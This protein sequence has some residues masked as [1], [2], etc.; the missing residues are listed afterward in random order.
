M[1]KISLRLD[2]ANSLEWQLEQVAVNCNS[3][4]MCVLLSVNLSLTQPLLG[5]QGW[6]SS[7]SVLCFYAALDVS[8]TFPPSPYYGGI[9]Q[10]DVG[11]DHQS[12]QLTFLSG[13]TFPAVSSIVLLSVVDPLLVPRL[14]MLSSCSPC[15]SLTIVSYSTPD[16][17]KVMMLP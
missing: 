6:H 17:G 7:T 15:P 9:L 1:D 10:A 3:A 5:S 13:Y 4:C 11:T 2:C 8:V 16:Q 14:I 12:N